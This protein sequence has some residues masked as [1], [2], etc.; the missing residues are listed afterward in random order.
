MRRA[1]YFG[2]LL[3][4]A[5]ALGGCAAAEPAEGTAAGPRP[6]RNL[7]TQEELAQV[8]FGNAWDAVR[9]MR[10]HWLQ[11]RQQSLGGAGSGLVM[12]YLDG[13]RMGGPDSLRQI[14]LSTVQQMQYLSA[15]EATS[16]YGIDHTAGAILVTTRR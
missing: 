2:L 7:I 14:P 5:I 11:E 1:S 12:V 10:T 9:S 13:T 16:R 15:P 8:H 4:L 6:S 3:T